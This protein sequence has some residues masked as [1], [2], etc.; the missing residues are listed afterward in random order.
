MIFLI[1]SIISS[2]L[3]KYTWNDKSS[4]P[5]TFLL[6]ILGILLHFSNILINNNLWSTSI[7][8]WQNISPHL[9]LN[10]FVPPLIYNSSAHINFHVLRQ[11]FYQILVLIIPGVLLSSCVISLFANKIIGLCWID[12]LLL[13]TI[14]SATD[15][16]AVTKILE[17][18]H[19]SEK[20]RILIEGE[21]LF[22]DGTVYVLFS[23][24]MNYQ[25]N[26]TGMLIAKIFY[27]PILSIIYGITMGLLLCFILKHIYNDA[28]VEISLTIIFCY[29]TF[30]F[31]DTILTLSGIL[32]VVILGLFISWGG[33]TAVSHNIKYSMNHVWEVLDFSM[34]NIIFVLTGLIGIKNI[35]YSAVNVGKL[36]LLY[37]SINLIR[38]A[39]IFLFYPLLKCKIYKIY[40]KELSIV[41]LSGLRGA[42]TLVLALITGSNEIL[43][44]STGIV[45]LSIPL[46]SIM[47]K[48]FVSHVLKH[49]YSKKVES[50]LHIREKLHDVGNE[51][52]SMIKTDFYLKNIS[53]ETVHKEIITRPSKSNNITISVN[54]TIMELRLIYLKTFKQTLWSLFGRNMIYRD[55]IIN[56]LEII[57]NTIDSNKKIIEF[58]DKEC[59]LN[60]CW[61]EIFCFNDFLKQ[62]FLYHKINHRY[63]LIS[64]Y[65]LGQK[66]TLENLHVILDNNIH[67]KTLE[68]ENNNS[69]NYCLKFLRFIECNYPNITKKIETRQTIHFILKNQVI[70]LKKL[71][72]NGEINYY[73]YNEISTEIYEKLYS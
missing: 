10:V 71:F 45:F 29:A 13:G 28:V 57:D 7:D 37:V 30:Y 43:F 31:S 50:I 26:T 19:I 44:Y 32:S 62:K 64:A 63:N 40:F 56:L 18:L 41:S 72:R 34:N 60:T 23:L 21:S 42:L 69:V 27:I 58:S 35:N 6:I 73:I 67:Y 48:F 16:V 47:V 59:N 36:L 12:S 61:Y 49:T 22:N 51:T 24:L 15:P 11:Y 20:I 3:I 14:L 52:I 55:T 9:I 65:V 38:F 1:I 39:M 33:K 70:Y 66:Y 46:N 25:E 4:L 53:W 68:D 54:E 17:N 2:S 5:F 8:Y